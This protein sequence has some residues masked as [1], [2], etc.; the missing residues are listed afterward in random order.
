MPG[1]EGLWPVGEGAGS[2]FEGRAFG[3]TIVEGDG[4]VAAEE[5]G[6]DESELRH[7]AGHEAVQ[8]AVDL[9]GDEGGEEDDDGE[10][11]QRERGDPPRE[12]SASASAGGSSFAFSVHAEGAPMG[13]RG[14]FRGAGERNVVR[15][16][17]GVAAADERQKL[18]LD[19]R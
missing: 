2:D 1:E 3:T 12:T 19:G 5:P 14:R 16:S 6:V 15:D 8:D 13:R 10:S 4:D 11:T 18:A 17:H 7:A 9:A